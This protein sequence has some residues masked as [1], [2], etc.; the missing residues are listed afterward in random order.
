M[1]K[2][3]YDYSMKTKLL[4]IC[5]LLFTSQVFAEER[6]IKCQYKDNDVG[7]L[8]YSE[9]F[10]GL[11]K[12]I[13]IRR[14]IEWEDWCVMDQPYKLRELEI[15]DYGG[16]CTT[17]YGSSVAS[18]DKKKETLVIDFIPPKGKTK[19]LWRDGASRSYD[20]KC[21]FVDKD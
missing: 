10:F 14:E 1:S 8:K 11:L 4:T 19:I 18:G 9:S 2:S 5:L 16:R 3:D 7:V 15:S 6:I 20:F 21:S 12:K 17:I 13:Q